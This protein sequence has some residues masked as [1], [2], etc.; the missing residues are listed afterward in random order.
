MRDSRTIATFQGG[1]RIQG[2]DGVNILVL[3]QEHATPD[4]IHVVENGCP[5]SPDCAMSI[6]AFQAGRG[7]AIAQLHLSPVQRDALLDSVLAS[8][9]ATGTVDLHAESAGTFSLFETSDVAITWIPDRNVRMAKLAVVSCAMAGRT[10]SGAVIYRRDSM[11]PNEWRG[12]HLTGDLVHELLTALQAVETA[13][14][15]R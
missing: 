2:D 10:C 11:F 1:T 6:M 12:M 9:G 8:A 4:M 13:S 14:G 3:I 7:N 5:G 15:R